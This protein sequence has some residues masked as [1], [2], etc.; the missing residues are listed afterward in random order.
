MSICQINLLSLC[1]NSKVTVTLFLPFFAGLAKA[2]KG[3]Y[4]K[5]EMGLLKN[6]T[7]HSSSFSVKQSDGLNGL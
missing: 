3:S 5:T 1:H 2:I 6:H 7:L 4:L